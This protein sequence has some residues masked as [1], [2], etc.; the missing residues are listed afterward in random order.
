M[1]DIEIKVPDLGDFE[2]VPVIEILVAIGDVVEVEQG[3]V[4]VESDKATMDIPSPHAGKITS[5]NIATGDLINQG[6]LLVTVDASASE[7]VV[8]SAAAA[9]PSP[10]VTPS[11]ANETKAPPAL[12][13]VGAAF[14]VVVIG[15]GPG[16]YS[17]AFRAADLGLKVILIEKRETL[18]GV[19]LNVGCIPSKALL[20]V[21]EI[22]REAQSIAANGV[23]FGAP[24]FDL[25]KLR[26]FKNQTITKLTTGLDGMAKARKVEVVQGT[27]RLTGGGSLC[28]SQGDGP[29][30]TVMF[31]N[32]IIAAGSVV[33]HLSFLPGDPRIVDSTGALELPFIPGKMLVIGGG[34]IGLEMATVYSALGAKV[35]V[36]EMADDILVGL[37]KDLVGIWKKTNKL[38]I[39]D[40]FLSTRVKSVEARDDGI[41][42]C[43]EG[44]DKARHYDFVLQAAGRRPDSEAL[45]LDV[46]GVELEKGFI[47]VDNQMRTSVA[48]IFAIGDIAGPPMLAH[49]AVHEGH[50]AAEAAAGEKSGFDAQIIPSV[51]YT[52]PEIAWTGMTEA[53]ARRSGIAINVAKFPWSASGRAIANGAEYGQTKMIFSKETGRVIGGAIIGPNAG[54]MI[55]EICLAIELGADA[56]DIGKTIHPHPTLGETIGMAA[57]VGQGICTDLPPQ[58]KSQMS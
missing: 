22:S 13:N 20:H 17:A 10:S 16:G 58:K 29:D 56:I 32:C 55:G 47:K 8:E 54:D 18:G 51:A 12:G 33:A 26:A 46:A 57:E 3:L 31:K 2:N 1:Q 39:G 4:T 38:R 44:E 19:C 42:V 34:V 21:A 27:A 37:D 50:V 23:T 11:V 40:L 5:I 52:D 48:N 15:G 9:S 53:D 24:V 28:V 14:D 49:K 35:D 45:G 41:L 43:F 7:N 6:A 36:V 25:N 30:R